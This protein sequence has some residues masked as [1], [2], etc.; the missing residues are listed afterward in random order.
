MP[1]EKEKKLDRLYTLLEREKDE[2]T[3]AALRWAIFQL[4]Q[5]PERE[6]KAQ[7]DRLIAY[8]MKPQRERDGIIDTGAFNSII[9]GYTVIALQ[10]AGKP[11][12]DIKEA[13]DALESAFEDTDA[14]KARRAYESF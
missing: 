9:A 10:D 3:A 13:L 6:H 8:A 1:S 12:N 11:R 2:D 5:M 4:E 14:E 7:A